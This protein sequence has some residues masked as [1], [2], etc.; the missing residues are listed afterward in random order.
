[1]A[2]S[3]GQLEF[4]ERN[5]FDPFVDLRAQTQVRHGVAGEEEQYVVRLHAQGRARAPEVSMS[6]D[7][8]LSEGDIVSLLTLGFTSRSRNDTTNTGIGL[9]SEALLTVTGLDRQVQ[10]LL[11]TGLLLKDAD[12]QVST[13]YNPSS[14]T[15]EPTVQLESRFLT[16]ELSL[17]IAQP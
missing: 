12:V 14:G 7:P 5:A 10:R 6:S 3:G 15:S 11:P 4:T 2:L 1:F 13:L 9:L 8:G 17:Q 16:E